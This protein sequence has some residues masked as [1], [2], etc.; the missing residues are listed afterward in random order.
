VNPVSDAEMV[1]TTDPDAILTTKGGGT[2]VIAYYDNDLID[3]RV[4]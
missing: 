1:S 2:A 3:P 4:G